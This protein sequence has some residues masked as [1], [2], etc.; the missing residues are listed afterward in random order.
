MSVYIRSV[1]IFDAHLTVYYL[2]SVNDKCG[3]QNAG[4]IW[5][6]E[7]YVSVLMDFLDLD[8]ANSYASR[9][10]CEVCPVARFAS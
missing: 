1:G 9:S 6:N 5:H 10:F 4:S 2:V 7:N 8:L 3:L